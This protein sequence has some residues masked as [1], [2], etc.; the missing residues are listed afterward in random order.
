[1]R[2]RL[3]QKSFRQIG[4]TPSTTILPPEH[5]FVDSTPL[6]RIVWPASLIQKLTASRRQTTARSLILIFHRSTTGPAC[7]FP[8]P[9]MLMKRQ[10]EHPM[11]CAQATFLS[12]PFDQKETWLRWSLTRL[13]PIPLH[14]MVFVFCDQARFS[15]KYFSHIARQRLSRK[16]FQGMLLHQCIRQLPTRMYWEYLSFNHRQKL[17]NASLIS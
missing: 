15:R 10:A 1:M 2:R 14:Q 17:Q 12:V 16:F 6:L 8:M 5:S 13:V 11:S 4:L 3:F 7:Y 9:F